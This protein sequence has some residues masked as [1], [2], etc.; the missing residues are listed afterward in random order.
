MCRD[1]LELSHLAFANDLLTH[2]AEAN[3]EHVE[4]INYYPDLFRA[5]YGQKVNKDNTIIFFSKTL[6][7][8]FDNRLVMSG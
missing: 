4:V 1:G 6:H 3:M 7:G 2:F 5:S 8:N